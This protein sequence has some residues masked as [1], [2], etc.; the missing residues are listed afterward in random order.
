MAAAYDYGDPGSPLGNIHPEYKAPVGLRLS[1]GAQALAYGAAVSY[2]NPTIKAVAVAG[3]GKLS[4]TFD[5]PVELAAP[6]RGPCPVT[7]TSCAW[8]SVNG[9]NV[10]EMAVQDGTIVVTVPAEVSGSMTVRYLQGD[11]PVPTI[12]A[13]GVPPP[14]LPAAPFSEVVSAE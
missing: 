9:A 10:T 8:L 6:A 2:K 7:P 3:A 1:L 14:G 12:Y 11:W 13:V 5:V 4:L